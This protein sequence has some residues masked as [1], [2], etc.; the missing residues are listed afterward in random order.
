MAT[1]RRLEGTEAR[2]V[3]SGGAPVIDDDGVIV[4]ATIDWLEDHA[5]TL[6]EQVA[7]ELA[8][9]TAPAGPWLTRQQAAARVGCSLRHF[10]SHV[11]PSLPSH[12]VGR[13]VR[14][15]A[16]EV[17][18]WLDTQKVSGSGARKGGARTSFASASTASASKSPRAHRLSARLSARPSKSTPTPS[19][20]R[21]RKPDGE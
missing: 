7:A 21:N 3:A 18:A 11:R 17:D 9:A 5:P 13:G 8:A 15:K 12:P 1:R 2:L 6:A 4:E 10:D 14:F 16:E 20:E 19:N